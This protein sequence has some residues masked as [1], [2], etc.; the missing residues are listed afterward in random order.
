MGRSFWTRS[1]EICASWMHKNWICCARRPTAS[2]GRRRPRRFGGE[3]LAT[4]CRPRSQRSRRAATGRQRDRRITGRRRHSGRMDR[5][6]AGLDRLDSGQPNPA[7]AD[8]G[9]LNPDRRGL[10]PTGRPTVP[11]SGRL[12]GEAT[13]TGP[14]R[15]RPLA[16]SRQRAGPSVLNRLVGI[17]GP[18]RANGLLLENR[19]AVDA[20]SPPNR[21]GRSQ[22]AKTGG[23]IGSRL[24]RGRKRHAV[25]LPT[26]M[27]IS[28]QRGRTSCILSR[29]PI[30]RARNGLPGQA[31]IVPRR[32]AQGPVDRV[33]RGPSAVR[34]GWRGLL[35]PAAA[36]RGRAGRGQ[37]ANQAERADARTARAQDA[38]GR[39]AVPIPGRALG[40]G[41]LTARRRD[42]GRAVRALLPSALSGAMRAAERL[43]AGLHD[44]SLRALKA[45]SDPQARRGPVRA[46]KIR[47]PGA[48]AARDGSPSQTLPGSPAL[49]AVIAPGLSPGPSRAGS[50][51]PAKPAVPVQN[52][53]DQDPEER[54][55]GEGTP[56]ASAASSGE[57]FPLPVCEIQIVDTHGWLRTKKCP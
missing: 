50:R 7:R 28:D 43:R 13:A 56:A 23:R 33:R 52:A 35:P 29:F 26:R 37:A 15:D 42:A 46:A 6:A 22:R 31:P 16:P 4:R 27:R 51:S 53:A 34:A 32:G 41:H 12:Q 20:A 36:S 57:K 9:Q 19:R 39:A 1:R 45:L 38:V 30:L 3:I 14:R 44:R 24:R 11:P 40:S 8:S 2:C 5:C 55:R 48:R 47:D 21:A 18:S 25:R 10:G 17:L 54:G 49:A